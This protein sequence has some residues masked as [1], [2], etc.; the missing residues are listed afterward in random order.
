MGPGSYVGADEKRKFTNGPLP[1]A[2]L[3]LPELPPEFA[4]RRGLLRRFESTK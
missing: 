2:A 1:P 4:L 3:P